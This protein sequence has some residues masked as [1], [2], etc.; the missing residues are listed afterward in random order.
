MANPFV[1]I[2][3]NTGDIGRARSFYKNLFKWNLQL[4]PGMPY[5]M[6]DFGTKNTMG[7][8]MQTKPMPDAPTQWLAYVQVD[9][10]KQTVARARKL[11]AHIV[12]PYQTM[13]GM[14][15]MGI[16][17]DPTGGALGVWE[18]EKKPARRA[19]KP[20]KPAK[21]AKS[22]KQPARRT[23]TRKTSRR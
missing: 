12:V 17:V 1:H 20:A 9:D 8:G 23:A 6:I 18:P 22:A 10:V 16:F 14:G 7:G 15:A 11:G 4:T 3:L 13:P 19:A 2:E 5:T 21:S